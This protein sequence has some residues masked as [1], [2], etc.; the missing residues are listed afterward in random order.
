MA[1]HFEDDAAEVSAEGIDG[2]EKA[3]REVCLDGEINDRMAFRARADLQNQ[4]IGWMRKGYSSL[5]GGTVVRIS[6][7]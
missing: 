7:I 2:D 4:A 1:E 6:R 5:G 3:T